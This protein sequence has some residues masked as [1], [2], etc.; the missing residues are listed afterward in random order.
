MKKIFVLLTLLLAGCGSPVVTTPIVTVSATPTATATSAA[1]TTKVEF[2]ANVVGYKDYVIV[3][4]TRDG[5]TE[6]LKGKSVSR[7][8]DISEGITIK[9]TSEGYGPSSCG[10]KVGK[11]VQY[12]DTKTAEYVRKGEEYVGELNNTVECSYLVP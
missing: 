1:P 10:I 3:D 8:Y 9:V 4:I 11:S 7:E 12:A 6:V 5:T 2:Q